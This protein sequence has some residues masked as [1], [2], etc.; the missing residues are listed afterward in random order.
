MNSLLF[1]RPLASIPR[2]SSR[3]AGGI[4]ADSSFANN[5]AECFVERLSGDRE[6]IYILNL[7]R[8]VAKN[9][10]GKAFM[11]QF[12]SNLHELRFDPNCR[13]LIVRSLVDRVFC[14]GADLKERQKMTQAEV[15]A[16]VHGLRTAFVDLETLP[17]PT[18]SAIDGAAMGG[19]LE[20]ALATDMRVAGTGAKLALPETKLAIIPGAGGTQR[21]PR[22]IG[23]AKAKELIFTGRILNYKQSV[24]WGLCNYAVEGSAFD[25]AVELAQEILPQGPIAIRMAKLAVDRGIQLDSASGMAFEQ[26][27]YA[28][29]IPTEDRL[30]GLR[31]FQEKRKPVYK[32]Q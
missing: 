18:I 11:D 13:V 24:D 15:A 26:T 28:Q 2:I 8:P 5:A 12:R 7:N 10:L 3:R 16:F 21:L 19:G 4:R 22:L 29:V 30:E 27:C 32:G 25:K 14:A 31:A 6:G 9:A 20:V 23:A 1:R 17:M